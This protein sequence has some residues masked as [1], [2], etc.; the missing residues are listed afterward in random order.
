MFIGNDRV[1]VSPDISPQA[2]P[3]P[4]PY[5]QS[6]DHEN[7][8]LPDRGDRMQLD[9]NFSY[10]PRRGTLPPYTPYTEVVAPHNEALTVSR[11]SSVS[12][13][14]LATL[15]SPSPPRPMSGGDTPSPVIRAMAQYFSHS[16][17]LLPNRHAPSP[18]RTPS[19]HWVQRLTE[20]VRA[21]F[22]NSPSPPPSFGRVSPFTL[23][24]DYE[25][26]SSQNR[27]ENTTTDSLS[28]YTAPRY[29]TETSSFTHLSQNTTPASSSTAYSSPHPTQRIFDTQNELSSTVRYGFSTTIQN[30][31][32][33]A[34]NEKKWKESISAAL[35]RDTREDLFH[36]LY[37]AKKS[38]DD[39]D[40]LNKEM[41]RALLGFNKTAFR[42]IHTSNL[43]TLFN[44]AQRQ[45]WAN[46]VVMNCFGI[47]EEQ[48]INFYSHKDFAKLSHFIQQHARFT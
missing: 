27:I 19:P 2:T 42:T 23:Y 5:P 24:Y 26:S 39:I 15:L 48:L 21:V 10:D 31:R 38:G 41:A 11:Q 36:I 37:A 25:G 1:T 29:E 3:S 45:E 46:Q 20:T 34:L 35:D 30:H 28:T 7:F 32:S 9:E 14:R 22:S 4:P 18:I 12:P 13:S 8:P 16:S 6:H 17:P 47:P 40:L 44:P 43:R 33:H